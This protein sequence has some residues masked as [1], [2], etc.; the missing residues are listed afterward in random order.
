MIP[1][2][3]PLKFQTAFVPC[4][5]WRGCYP[6]KDTF[7]LPAHANLNLAAYGDCVTISGLHEPSFIAV[8][9]L[10]VTLAHAGCFSPNVPEGVGCTRTDA[11]PNNTHCIDQVCRPQPTRV[12]AVTAGEEHSC[13]LLDNGTVVCWGEWFQGRL[14]YGGL[15]DSVG[16]DECAR[17]YGVVNLGGIVTQLV[18]GGR[19][20]CVLF[21]NGTVSCW[22]AGDFGQ[23]GFG[24]TDNAGEIGPPANFGR[25]DIGGVAVQLTAGR[26]HSCA[27]RS[28]GSVVC[29]GRGAFGRLG[30]GNEHNIG[31]DSQE[32]PASAGA[33]DLGGEA[34]LISAGEAHTCAIMTNGAVR[35]WGDGSLGRLGYGNENHVGHAGHPSAVAPIVFDDNVN[36]IAAG[37][38]HTCALFE[39]GD[40][41]CWGSGSSGSIGYGNEL[42]ILDATLSGNV[43]LGAP[44]KELRTWDHTCASYEDGS[45]RC[46]G[47]SE[48][49]RLGYGDDTEDIADNPGEL[50]T[51][52]GLVPVGDA[53]TTIATGRTHT[54]AVTR[55]GKVRCWGMNNE[56]QL[57]Y[58]DCPTTV[59]DNQTCNL[60]DDDL[61]RDKAAFA[62][63]P[64]LPCND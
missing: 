25:V 51:S 44:V 16:D 23:L 62:L 6:T 24:S 46:W 45:L 8:A 38:Q 64:D 34:R 2:S 31:D 17:A 53:V 63:L 15:R 22:G 27:L 40:V 35:C 58:G 49:G 43:E 61:P 29:W 7:A 21:D 3:E 10:S 52:V 28:D 32:T 50:P 55:A 37:E 59:E 33:I 5:R 9:T 47:Q 39:H 13:G 54:C 19:H 41:R 56:G 20:N 4:W 1:L 18:T 60:G 30:Y 14:G 36:F 57:G 11:C 26:D 12:T 48:H 42:N